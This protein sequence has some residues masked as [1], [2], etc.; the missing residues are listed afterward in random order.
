MKCKSYTELKSTPNLNIITKVGKTDLSVASR[1][2]H[3]CLK[4]Y[5]NR[6]L[7]YKCFGMNCIRFEV[8]SHDL[9]F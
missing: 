3:L 2:F 5:Y 9:K 8:L 7:V 4:Y 6:G 1:K